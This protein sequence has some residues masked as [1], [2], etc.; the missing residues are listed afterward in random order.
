MAADDYPAEPSHV[1]VPMDAAVLRRLRALAAERDEPLEDLVRAHLREWLGDWGLRVA[2]HAVRPGET[3]WSIARRYY[4]DGR[5]ANVLAAYN[6]VEDPALLGTGDVIRV[7]EPQ[8]S[9]DFPPG[10]SPYLHGLEGR[11]GEYLMER[12][13]KPGWVLLGEAV[14]AD[15]R[16]RSGRSYADLADRGF[17]VIVRLEHEHGEGGTLPAEGRH[18]DF[19]RRC[20]NFCEHSPGCHIWVIGEAPNR[21]AARPGGPRHG[22]PITPERYAAA[23][24]ACREEIRARPGHQD[25]QVLIAA[26]APGIAQTRY[27]GNPNGDWVRYFADVLALLE[28]HLDGIALHAIG[29]CPTADADG[30]RQAAPFGKRRTGLAA[31]QD[32]LGAV[33]EDLGRLPVFVTSAGPDVGWDAADRGWIPAAYTAVAE[34]NLTNPPIRCMILHRWPGGAGS[35]SGAGSA[36]SPWAI[37]GRRDVVADLEAAIRQGYRWDGWHR[38]T[39]R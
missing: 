11:G 23:Y 21:A 29:P 16:D 3:L 20:A 35:A 24:W 13:G 8:V 22:E 27:A 1:T 12:A 2:T 38:T 15:P 36:A 28:G 5:K 7:P 33:P 25:D 37:E 34:W 31:Y 19:A 10:E 9:L 4:G 30:A 6:D 39:E 17:G 26:I 32:F 14:G 18:G